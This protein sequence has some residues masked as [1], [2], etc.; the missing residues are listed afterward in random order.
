VRVHVHLHL[1]E[2]E[3]AETHEREHRTHRVHALLGHVGRAHGLL[4][5]AVPFGVAHLPAV[6]GVQVA[7]VVVGLE[8][9][10]LL[11]DEL[12]QVDGAVFVG[13]LG[14]GHQARPRHVVADG[15]ALRRRE[16]GRQGLVRQQPEHGLLVRQ[17]RAETVD[18]AHRAVAVGLHQRMRQVEAEQKLLHAQAPV[19]QV[20]FEWA[21]TQHA[22]AVLELLGRYDLHR[23]AVLAEEIAEQFVLALAGMVSRTELHDGDVGLLRAAELPVRFQQRLQKVPPA[24]GARQRIPLAEFLHGGG[25]EEQVGQGVRITRPRGRIRIVLN[26]TQ[27]SVG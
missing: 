20:D 27:A 26:E 6:V 8:R 4:E 10:P 2:L 1:P 25:V 22:V 5:G 11:G 9:Q 7:V 3:L 13:G 24:A 19:H 21:F 17:F 18:H 23:V 12:G 15:L 14:R 16:L